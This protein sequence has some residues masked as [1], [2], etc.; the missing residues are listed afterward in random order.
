MVYL[1]MKI[2]MF[3]I[4]MSLTSQVCGAIDT[5]CSSGLKGKHYGAWS[6]MARTH[7][8]Y[9]ATLSTVVIN[10]KKSQQWSSHKTV[11]TI[12]VVWEGDSGFHF[13]STIGIRM[14]AKHCGLQIRV[15]FRTPQW[16][17]CQQIET[18]CLI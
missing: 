5:P 7:R 14:S 4:L 6:R 12:F 18:F 2:T 17:F 11:N 3:Q 1:T 13:M 8:T 9:I 15:G 16:H 10:H